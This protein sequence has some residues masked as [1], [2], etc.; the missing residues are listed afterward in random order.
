MLYSEVASLKEIQDPI[1]DLE[2]MH[3]HPSASLISPRPW[4]QDTP[5]V[6]PVY[7]AVDTRSAAF[8]VMYMALYLHIAYIYSPIFYGTRMC[9]YLCPGIWN[10]GP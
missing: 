3:S 7:H 8:P 9:V 10:S 4:L 2:T 1:A 6:C 5:L